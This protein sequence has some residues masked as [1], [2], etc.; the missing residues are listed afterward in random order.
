MTYLQTFRLSRDDLHALA[1]TDPMAKRL[2]RR[3]ALI[4]MLRRYM[5]DVTK[6]MRDSAYRS[7]GA[8]SS[9]LG[10]IKKGSP[11]RRSLLRAGTLQ[12]CRFKEAWL[13]PC[14]PSLTVVSSSP[15]VS[16]IEGGRVA[17]A[18]GDANGGD[19]SADALGDSC[20]LNAA[21]AEAPTS[22]DAADRGH[23]EPTTTRALCT[24]ASPATAGSSILP[25]ASVP[26]PLL[27]DS[28]SLA[29]QQSS[30][31]SVCS[32]RESSVATWEQHM[33]RRHDE[34][35][36]AVASLRADVRELCSIA[37]SSRSLFG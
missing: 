24:A 3:Y 25:A 5:L 18:A 19:C 7:A 32:T 23:D 27:A 28:P 13:T 37:R 10:A 36:S 16:S 8:S 29:R 17:S 31:E 33:E 30:G 26:P 11:Y 2:L 1:E 21:P 9:S 22:A 20:E 6:H 4:L 35:A 12:S 14:Q 34:L 15:V